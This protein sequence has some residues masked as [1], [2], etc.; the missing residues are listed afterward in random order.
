[1][2]QTVDKLKVARAVV[3]K[4]QEDEKLQAVQ[5]RDIL[6]LDSPNKISIKGTEKKYVPDIIAFN[7]E[8]ITIYEIVMDDEAITSEK[9]HIL[10]LYARNKNGNLYL[11]VPDFLRE[12]I[13]N[14]IRKNE[15][16]AGIIYF[17]T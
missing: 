11:V 14:E 10:S 16:N 4:I 17:N 8:G 9:W 1:M 6:G 3:A 2:A 15:I 7:N 12:R 5:S 13:K